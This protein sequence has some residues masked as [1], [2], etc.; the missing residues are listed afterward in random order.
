MHGRTE[1]SPFRSA[2][3]AR[4]RAHHA[5]ARLVRIERRRVVEV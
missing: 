4:A 3:L 5:T 1:P 2:G